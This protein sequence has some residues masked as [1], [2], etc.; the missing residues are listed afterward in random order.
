MPFQVI[1]EVVQ[2]Y[3][4]FALVQT[5]HSASVGRQKVFYPVNFLVG[6]MAFTGHEDDIAFTGHC[7]SGFNGLFCG[8]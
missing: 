3:L 8:R 2:Q 4:F 5:F 7:N 1:K 6:F